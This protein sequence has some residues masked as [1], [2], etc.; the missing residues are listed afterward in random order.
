MH[1]LL[2]DS[3]RSPSCVVQR[4]E[5]G[6]KAVATPWTR[7][8]FLSLSTVLYFL[9]HISDSTPHTHT[10]THTHTHSY[11]HS[12]THTHTHIHTHTHTHTHTHIY[13]YMYKCIYI[14]IYIYICMYKCIYWWLTT[15]GLAVLQWLSHS[16]KAKDLVA[17]SP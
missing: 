16:G 10:H 3:D 2:H 7:T 11:T 5:I 17:V 6:P 15:C 8:A 9:K 1:R 12:Y 13:I 4:A 14:Y